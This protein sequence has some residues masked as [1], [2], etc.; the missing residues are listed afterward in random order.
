MAKM[1]QHQLEADCGSREY[2]VLA[3]KF[4]MRAGVPSP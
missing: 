4:A 3:V 1:T 2:V